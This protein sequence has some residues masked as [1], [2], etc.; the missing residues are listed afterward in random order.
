MQ[1]KVKNLLDI[2]SD[3]RIGRFV[4]N[5]DGYG[6]HMVECEDGWRF[7]G[8]RT[9]EIGNIKEICY[10]INNNLERYKTK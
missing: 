5:Y 6:K 9:I 10:S 4:K 7:E 8:E 2:Y 3:K 1:K